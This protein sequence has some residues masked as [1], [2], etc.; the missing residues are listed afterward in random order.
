M[1]RY[2]LRKLLYLAIAVLPAIAG[3]ARPLPP[4]ERVQPTNVSLLRAEFGGNATAEAATAAAPAAE[5]T[6]W[7]TI[8]GTFKLSG[9]A[10][11]L[12]TI[13]ANKD[14]EVCAPGGRSIPNQELEVDSATQGI[15]DII[16]YLSG[17]GKF[18]AGNEKWEHPSY[19]DSREA[20]FEF[21]QKNCVFLTHTL[22]MRSSQHLKILNSDPVGH[23]TKIDATGRAESINATIPSGSSVEYSPRGESQEPF[24]VSCS[25]HPWMSARLISRDSPYFTVTKTDGSFEIANVPAGVPLEFRIWQERAKFLQEVTVN[26]KA[27]KWPKGRLKVTLQPDQPLTLEVVVDAGVFK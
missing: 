11:E 16:V 19:A 15:R 23:N 7:A 9:A 4:A 13:V 14:Q 25:I 21:D 10:P 20:T 22:A 12:P 18:P 26:G 1:K 2:Q 3:C 6:G 8:K 17:P 27:E 24:P 5:P